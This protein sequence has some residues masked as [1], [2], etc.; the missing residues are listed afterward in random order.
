MKVACSL[1]MSLAC[2]FGQQQTQPRSPAT[3]VP[4]KRTLSAKPKAIPPVLRQYDYAAQIAALQDTSGLTVPSGVQPHFASNN[5]PGS[6]PKGLAPKTDA[7]LTPTALE[8]V[9]L[10]GHWVSEKNSPATGEDG[11]VLYSFGAGL[12][13][14]VCAPLR[15]CIVELKP[16]E[17]IVGEPHIGDSVRWNISPAVYGA[18]ESATWVLVIKPQETGLDTN[19]FVSTDRRAYYLRLLSN[20]QEY[21]ARVAFKYPQ[22]QNAS[23]HQQMVS[24]QL[25]TK[26]RSSPELTPA[27]IALDKLHFDYKIHG[28]N[29]HIRPVR[30]FD[31]GQKTFIQMPPDMQFRQAPALLVLGPS[32]KGEMTNY[33]VKDQMYIVDRLFDR[34]QLVLGSGKK[35]QKVEISHGNSKG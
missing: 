13:V 30:V 7:M 21:V 26:D 34:A 28:G 32:G 9:K 18:G 15:V 19:L 1:L 6:V 8:A 16:G 22:E 12:P 2:V 24:Q 29:E 23:W 10:S 11:R 14:V 33:R 17:K 4:A 27:M 20:P 5:L 25:L 3:P 31:D 35:A